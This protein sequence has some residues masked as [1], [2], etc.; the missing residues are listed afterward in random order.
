MHDYTCIMHTYVNNGCLEWMLIKIWM[1]FEF[2]ILYMYIYK[3]GE[4]GIGAWN[5]SIYCVGLCKHTMRLLHTCRLEKTSRFGSILANCLVY[6]EI[7]LNILLA[8]VW[9]MGKFC[10]FFIKFCFLMA[11]FILVSMITCAWNILHCVESH[12]KRKHYVILYQ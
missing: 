12:L 2:V 3:F 6:G 8:N 11:Q 5:F 4:F 7:L 9:F 1:V 10:I